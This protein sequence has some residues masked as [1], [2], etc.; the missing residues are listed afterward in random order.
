MGSEMSIRDGGYALSAS[1]L[2]AEEPI[3]NA[4]WLRGPVKVHKSGN[5][6]PP[7]VSKETLDEGSAE[8]QEDL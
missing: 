7:Q 2:Q 4:L 5:G 3:V 6:L 1:F 8:R